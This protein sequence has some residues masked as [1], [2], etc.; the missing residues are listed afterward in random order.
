MASG[1][2]NLINWLI[3]FILEPLDRTDSAN[4]IAISHIDAHVSKLRSRIP[5]LVMIETCARET[6]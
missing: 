5:S 3:E 1:K 4:R 2:A 6:G